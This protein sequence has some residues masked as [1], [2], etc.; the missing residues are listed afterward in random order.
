LT[1]AGRA[2]VPCLERVHELVERLWTEA[3]D[4]QPADRYRFET[5]VIEVAG[6][7]VEHG[8][9]QVRLRLWL[10]VHTDRVEAQFRDTGRAVDLATDEGCM[11]DLM[12]EDGRGL[13]LARATADELTYR[14][15]GHTN[16]WSVTKMRTSTG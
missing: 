1:L 14:R 16:S 5:A 11:P 12:A 10:R 6:N 8:G 13:A 4:V 3:P 15:T 7:I 9:P 2:D